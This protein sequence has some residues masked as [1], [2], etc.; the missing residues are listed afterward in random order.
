M[1]YI[2]SDKL[3]PRQIHCFSEEYYL[4]PMIQI[5]KKEVDLSSVDECWHSN[6]YMCTW[7]IVVR[8]FMNFDRN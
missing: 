1:F 3:K 8:T 5:E 4:K 7:P 2:L 6:W